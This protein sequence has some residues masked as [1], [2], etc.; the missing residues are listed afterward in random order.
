M[1]VIHTN[2]CDSLLNNGNVVCITVKYNLTYKLLILSSLHLFE[3]L[4]YVS[5]YTN[6]YKYNP[7]IRFDFFCKFDLFTENVKELNNKG[8]MTDPRGTPD[9]TDL[10][11][12]GVSK[13][14]IRITRSIRKIPI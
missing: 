5:I 13:T 2:Y 1:T 7:K 10:G 11:E 12:L 4:I 9:C 3:F 14:T 8:A 6:I